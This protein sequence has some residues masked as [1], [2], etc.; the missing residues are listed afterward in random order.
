MRF[1]FLLSVGI[2]FELQGVEVSTKSNFGCLAL[3]DET[4]CR[5]GLLIVYTQFG[6]ITLQL[7]L[8]ATIVVTNKELAVCAKMMF[9]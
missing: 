5:I 3:L 9:R 4:P 7:E 2:V 8:W 6:Q 1:L